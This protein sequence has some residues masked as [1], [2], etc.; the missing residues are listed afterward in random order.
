MNWIGMLF[1]GWMIVVCVILVYLF[2]YCC[3]LEEKID[4]EQEVIDGLY[5]RSEKA[6]S[7]IIELRYIVGKLRAELDYLEDDGK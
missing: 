5:S 6:A 7:E 3:F 4:N 1:C 2:R